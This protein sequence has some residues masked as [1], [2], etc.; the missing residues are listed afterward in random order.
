[1]PKF[2]PTAIDG[3]VL[4]EPKV[5]GD[6]RGYFFESYSQVAFLENIGTINFI[7]DNESKSSYGVLRGLHYQTSPFEQ[8]K[9]VHVVQGEVLDVVVDIRH[10]S[11]TYGQHLTL[12][13]S[14]ENKHQLFIPRGLAHGF[15]VLSELAIFQYKVDNIFSPDHERGILYHDPH[16][17]IDWGIPHNEIQVSPKDAGQPLFGNLDH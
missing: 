10:G 11:P 14:A 16:L 6:N 13:L 1:M 12:S 5:F 4:I 17:A 7:Q 3:V 15:V 9:L 2:F 8:A